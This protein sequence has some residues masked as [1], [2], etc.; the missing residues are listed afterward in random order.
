MQTFLAALPESF[1]RP[2][3]LKTA[4][5]IGINEKTAERYITDLCR[6]DQL[7]HPASG[8]YTKPS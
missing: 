5:D 3:Y 4:S 6:S 8:Q 7:D 2:T 1:D